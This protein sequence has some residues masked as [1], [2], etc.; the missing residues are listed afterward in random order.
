MEH[1]P[2]TQSVRESVLNKI[3]TNELTQ[4]PRIFFMLNVAAVVLVALAVLVLSVLIF[5]FILFMLRINSH[6]T[7]LG[8]GPRG[9]ELF[10]YVFPW[11][12]FFIDVFL[13]L[14]LEWLI[15]KFRI[16]YKIPALYLLL[17]LLLATAAASFYIDRGTDFND[18]LL[19]RAD[20]HELFFVGTFV[21]GARRPMPGSG[22]CVCTITAIAGNTL[23]VADT[24]SG[25]TTELTVLL[26][27][28]DPRATTTSLK[29]G[30]RVFIAGDAVSGALRA[31]GVRKV[32][33]QS[34]VR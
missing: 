21:E 9:L 11:P 7:L 10:I 23:T 18:K 17:G 5:N 26:P 3:R 13:V 32:P 4:R 15:R 14:A 29:V 20:R 8:F 12:L 34:K 33:V 6:D 24:R 16:G 1:N 22:V 30:D 2:H 31:F 28:D 25:T 19:H 27:L